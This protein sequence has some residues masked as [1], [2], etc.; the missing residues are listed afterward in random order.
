MGAQRL[1][2]SSGVSIVMVTLGN[3]GAVAVLAYVSPTIQAFFIWQ[4]IVGLVDTPVDTDRFDFFAA[5]RSH[6]RNSLRT[7]GAGAG[8]R[9][10]TLSRGWGFGT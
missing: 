9:T 3:L 7:L 1:T 2:V 8:I 4:G 5:S 10:R 6:Q